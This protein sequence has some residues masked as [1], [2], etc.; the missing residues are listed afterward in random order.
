MVDKHVRR[1]GS[2]YTKALL[3]LFPQGL[4]WPRNVEATLY[5]V[6]NGLAQVMGH[7]DGRAADLLTIESDPRVTDEMLPDWERNFGLPDLC[8]PYPPETVGER[9]TALVARMTMIGAQDRDFFTAL[10][11]ELGQ[12]IN[13][14]EYAPYMCGVSRCG[15]TR[16]SLY[17]ADSAHY[18]WQ[19]GP[20]EMRFH[21]TVDLT[22]VLSGA[23][24]VMR[25]YSPAHT[26]LVIKYNSTL[27][28][29][30]STYYLLG[31]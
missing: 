21:W 2:D 13:I 27:E 11:A 18:R 10:A 12:T 30:I 3:A 24:C 6:V 9:R 8:L 1:N 29:A 28:R 31:F 20:P 16:T 5:K 19:L 25:R 14:H 26:E 17:G 4:A 22:S 15:D 23:E 7:V